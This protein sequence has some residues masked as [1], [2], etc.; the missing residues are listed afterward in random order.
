MRGIALSILIGSLLMASTALDK[1]SEEDSELI[2]RILFCAFIFDL[3]LIVT[4]Y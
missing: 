1:I 4:G 3:I 2:G